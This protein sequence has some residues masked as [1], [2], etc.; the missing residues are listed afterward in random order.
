[1]ELLRN[2]TEASRGRWYSEGG[3]LQPAN[4][5]V[6]TFLAANPA[7]QRSLRTR[8]ARGCNLWV[9]CAG[10]Y[11]ATGYLK[12]DGGEDVGEWRATGSQTI[13][14]G[15]HPSGCKYSIIVEAPPAEIGYED[16]VWPT[17]LIPPNCDHLRPPGAHLTDETED[18][19]ET[20][21]TQETQKQG[22]LESPFFW[23]SHKIR[24]I[25]DLAFACRPE[26]VNRNHKLL[27]N[28][29]RG[30]VRFEQQRG[31]KFTPSELTAAFNQWHTAAKAFLREGQTKGEYLMEFLNG[32]RRVRHPLGNQA[33]QVALEQARTDPLP[34]SAREFEDEKIQLLI[35]WCW[36]L[37]K[38]VG[39]D[40]SFYISCRD[41]GKEL[42]ISHVTAKLGV[43]FCPPEY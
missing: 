27:F 30:L 40:Q 29:A 37:Q 26:T 32:Y 9:R 28:F 11:P 12:S 18:S 42:S 5:W 25:E 36:Q 8:G 31:V 43:G 20:Q 10:I 34:V 24:T 7:L 38:H 13:I 22:G 16:I 19:D 17:G 4:A 21:E 15:K 1:M 41:C 3:A 6:D 39:D 2:D 35:A 33:L 23:K 14:S